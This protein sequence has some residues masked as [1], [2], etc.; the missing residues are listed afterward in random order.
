MLIG[1]SYFYQQNYSSGRSEISAKPSCLTR[2]LQDEARLWLA[3]SLIVNGE[4]WIALAEHLA[5]KRFFAR[6][7][8]SSSP[9]ATPP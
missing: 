4:Y 2:G 8:G 1:K 7:D 3:R 6:T 9:S 5:T